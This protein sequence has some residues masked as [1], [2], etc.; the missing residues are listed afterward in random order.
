MLGRERVKEVLD[1]ALSLSSA[2]QTEALIMAED[3]YLTRFANSEIH[4]NVAERNGTLFVRVAFGKKIGHSS[5]NRLGKESIAEVVKRATEIASLQRENPDFI[6]L[7]GPKPIK[8]IPAFVKE[9]AAVTPEM[10]AEAAGKIIERAR[11][12][13]LD[14]FGT[15][16]TGVAELGVAN[17]LGVFGYTQGTDAGSSVVVMGDTNSGYAQQASR[18]FRKLDF[19]AI[20][21][22][23]VD[24]AQASR[25]PIE[26][27][28]GETVA[29]LE[30]AA[31]ADMLMFLGFLG[32]GALSVQEERSFMCGKFGKKIVGENISIWDDALD[33]RGFAVGFDFEGVP[34]QR[35]DFI[36]DGVASAVAY[37]SLTAGKEGKEST[38]HGLIAPN[39]YGPIPLSL[40]MGEGDSTIEEMIKDTKRGVYVTRFHYTNTVEPMRAVITGMT[41]DGTFLIEDGKIT[42]PLKNMRFTESI[43]SAFSCVT[44]IGKDAR[45][46]WE[47]A[48]YGPRFPT[49]IIT[50]AIRVEGFNFSGVT[51]F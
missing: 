42:K 26:L 33:E 2:D 5:T 18:D 1:R 41:R 47:G 29:V 45:L 25:D 46:Q 34:K 40:V 12:G 38:G 44:H 21:T 16:T 39:S 22:R 28:A 50:P 31:V 24:K 20:G 6:S 35:V 14:A 13:G 27:D 49:G 3:S 8:E 36:T 30:H 10:R 19:D 37:D 15:V 51:Q 11:K 4:Q 9:T 43:L 17:S 7:P 23:A 48:G 32:F